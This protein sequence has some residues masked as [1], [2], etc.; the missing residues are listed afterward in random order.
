MDNNLA[1]ASNNNLSCKETTN[2]KHLMLK[3]SYKMLTPNT[4]GENNHS[5]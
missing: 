5:T 4:I 3:S 2:T 1:I